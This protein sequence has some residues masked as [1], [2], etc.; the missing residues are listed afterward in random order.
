MPSL[1][2][3]IVELANPYHAYIFGTSFWYFLR[4]I[5]RVMDPATVAGW[6]RPPVMSPATPNDLELYTI[7]TDGFQLLTLSMILLVLGDAVPLPKSLAGSSLVETSTTTA[8]KKPYARAV[9]LLTIFHHVTTGFGAYQHWAKPTHHTAA[10]DIGV[11]GN[12]ALTALGI[13]ALVYGVPGE[14]AVSGGS[15][16]VAAG[17]RK[18][19][20]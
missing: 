9:I 5:M 16:G 1:F 11:Y 3:T 8:V 6:F 4:G 20:I 12:V 15:V 7:W 18:K 10:M 2:S 17:G 19:R 13:A 14:G